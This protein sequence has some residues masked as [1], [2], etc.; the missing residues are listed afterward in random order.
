MHDDGHEHPGMTPTSLKR[1]NYFGGTDV[2]YFL[3]IEKDVNF[4]MVM[5]NPLP[6][7]NARVNLRKTQASPQEAPP[8]A[9]M[10]N[11]VTRD[12]KG[13]TFAFELDDDE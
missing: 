1:F 8:V 3:G 7:M 2:A 12:D 11:A 10:V 4:P 5:E 9:Y 13:K 6:Y